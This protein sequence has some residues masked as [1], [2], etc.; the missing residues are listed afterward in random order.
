[1]FC[2]PPKTAWLSGVPQRSKGLTCGDLAAPSLWPAVCQA[3]IKWANW[4][5]CL[6]RHLKHLETRYFWQKKQSFH[7]ISIQCHVMKHKFW[8]F[9]VLAAWKDQD[10][11]TCKIPVELDADGK[12]DDSSIL[13]QVGTR[14]ALAELVRGI[15]LQLHALIYVGPFPEPRN[16]MKSVD[17]I[18]SFP[19]CKCNTSFSWAMNEARYV[20][21]S[22]RSG[23]ANLL[24]S[25]AYI[26]TLL[27]L[28]WMTW[29]SDPITLPLCALHRKSPKPKL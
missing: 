19:R 7:V 25:K 8:S 23:H 29:K 26:G 5:S 14:T 9:L 18:L 24:S 15:S 10:G 21:S 27:D 3:A 12:T 20:L 16:Q 22:M 6:L 13:K 28:C 2:P 1:M 11:L 4:S 17:L